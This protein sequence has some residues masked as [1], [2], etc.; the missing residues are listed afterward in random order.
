M[1]T[2]VHKVG[3]K[4]NGEGAVFA[5]NYEQDMQVNVAVKKAQKHFKSIIKLDKNFHIYVHGDRNKLEQGTDEK[6]NFYKVY[7]EKES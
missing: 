1:K 6:G 2:D 7:F 4:I 3:N 5:E